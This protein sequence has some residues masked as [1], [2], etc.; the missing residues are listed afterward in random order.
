[1]KRKVLI[2]FLFILSIGSPLCTWYYFEKNRLIISELKSENR[3]IED[4]VRNLSLSTELTF[5][6]KTLA[7]DKG[8]EN[9]IVLYFPKN[10]CSKCLE[11]ILLEIQNNNE[12]K[13]RVLLFF[14]D[15]ENVANIESFNDSYGSSYSYLIIDPLFDVEIS[16]IAFLNLHD[17]EIVG[18]LLIPPHEINYCLNI[19]LNTV[20]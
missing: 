2:G 5:E 1:M 13:N 20:L 3:K 8:L 6:A 4:R 15:K 18:V 9:K 19:I 14:D 16:D 7:I 12:L 10:G 11:N 17:G